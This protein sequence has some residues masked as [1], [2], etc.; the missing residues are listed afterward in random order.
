MK[1]HTRIYRYILEKLQQQCTHPSNSV[2]ADILEGAHPQQQIRWCRIC[3][4]YQ[5]YYETKAARHLSDWRL[6]N[7]R[8]PRPTWEKFK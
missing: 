5:F 4:A 1:L 2:V 7:W 6:P 3:G 8:T